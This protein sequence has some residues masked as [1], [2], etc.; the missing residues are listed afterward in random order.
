MGHLFSKSF[1]ELPNMIIPQN[2][3]HNLREQTINYTSQCHAMMQTDLYL[4][5]SQVFKVESSSISDT[6][7]TP[8]VAAK[9][10]LNTQFAADEKSISM[11]Q[12]GESGADFVV[13]TRVRYSPIGNL[14][15]RTECWV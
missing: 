11:V 12:M 2:R 9:T 15:Q 14:C 8:T 4:I 13:S 3:T 7:V 6:A 1:S 10:I 5:T